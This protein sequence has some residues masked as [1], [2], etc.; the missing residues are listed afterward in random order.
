MTAP[1][2]GPLLSR[3]P[4]EPWL[5]AVP[6]GRATVIAVEPVEVV[7]LNGD[8]A[9]GALDGLK[10]GWWA[11]FLSYELG[12]AVEPPRPGARIGRP[13]PQ[14]PDLLLARFES[15]LVLE[16]GGPPRLEGSGPSRLL[17]QAAL[18]AGPDAREPLPAPLDT[19][20]SSLGREQWIGAVERV[21]EHLAAGD[22]YQ[23]NLT[24][25]LTAE[26]CPDPVDLYRVL[27]DGN[28]APHCAL[29]RAGERSVV[30]ASPESFLRAGR[31][32]IVTRPIKGTASDPEV[33]SSSAKDRAENVMIVDLARNDLGRVCEYGTVNV[34]ALCELEPHP[35]LFHLVSTV[36]G[37]LRTDASIGDIIR[38]TFPA[39]SI[40]G[41]PKPRVLRII[42]HL[43]PVP[44]GVYCGA[45][46]W[47]DAGARSM[48][49]NVAIRTFE[50]SGGLT[51]FGVGGGI[52]ADSDPG[53][54]W[55]ETELKARRL[56]SL[57][58]GQPVPGE[59][60]VRR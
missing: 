30:S 34:D 58:S 14:T 44:R 1:A 24:R 57:A 41:A 37:S 26:G 42:E 35:G 46:G 19:W 32:R 3:L 13:P 25:R 49:L 8:A 2:T 15:R 48:D 27:L 7:E 60:P 17:L 50:M 16:P 53:A 23:V 56:L 10:S 22:C 54:E 18:D 43:E 47:I 11:G 31:G 12:Q 45:I 4:R 52:V 39:A 9:L 29:V 36:S 38:A 51:S 55:E 6:D 33:L 59:T 20:R 40:T 28:P 5:V 21:L